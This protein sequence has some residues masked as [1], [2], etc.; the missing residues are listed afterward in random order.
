[1][2][3]KEKFTYSDSRYSVSYD[4]E[5]FEVIDI[6]GFY[7]ETLLDKD[8]EECIELS[9]L[10]EE[11]K[12]YVLYNF[13]TFKDIIKKADKDIEQAILE[14]MNDNG[15]NTSLQISY[16]ELTS[17]DFY[18]KLYFGENEDE[19]YTEAKDI[20]SLLFG[21]AINNYFGGKYTDQ[22]FVQLRVANHTANV[23]NSDKTSL[24]AILDIKTRLKDPTESYFMGG[25]ANQISVVG[26]SLKEAIT[27]IEK[28]LMLQNTELLNDYLKRPA[29]FKKHFPDF[30]L[31]ES[32]TF[33]KENKYINKSQ[34]DFLIDAISYVI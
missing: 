12:Q 29:L 30:D 21:E 17:N 28:E 34:K 5:S 8:I 26:Y 33:I 7:I 10:S 18:N 19:V 1:M 27:I 11:D 23:R 16:R 14:S 9:E 25:Y 13:R 31:E 20:V 4:S 24:P 15:L 22:G 2:I 6:E 3:K 32:S